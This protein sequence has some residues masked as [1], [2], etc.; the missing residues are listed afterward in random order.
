MRSSL[1]W[2][3]LKWAKTAYF[4]SIRFVPVYRRRIS[5]FIS[6]HKKEKLN[7]FNRKWIAKKFITHSKN[8]FLKVFR[9]FIC[10]CF[11]FIYQFQT[12]FRRW[13]LI[14]AHCFVPLFSLCSCHFNKTGRNVDKINVD[15]SCILN[16]WESNIHSTFGS[17]EL[18]VTF[19]WF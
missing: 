5:C 13:L 17:Q 11:T 7:T 12:L 9:F 10:I 15:C 8:N 18:A 16:R 14:V 6:L 2:Q 4:W 1:W 3:H 19:K